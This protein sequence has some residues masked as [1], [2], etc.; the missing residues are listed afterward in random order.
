MA[1]FNSIAGAVSLLVNLYTV[2][3]LKLYNQR[4]QLDILI[5]D[6]NILEEYCVWKGQATWEEVCVSNSTFFNSKTIHLKDDVPRT[7][8]VQFVSASFF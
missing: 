3:L 7:W 4:R 2:L 5:L 6:G 1:T 8:W